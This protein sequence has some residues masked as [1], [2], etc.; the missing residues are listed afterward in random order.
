MRERLARLK[1]PRLRILVEN[2]YDIQKLRIMAGGR[3]WMYSELDAITPAQAAKLQEIQNDMKR[4]EGKLLK[5]IE[6]ELKSVPVWQWLKTVKGIG[7]AM[8][9]GLV[10][11][12]DDISR[13]PHVSSLWKY[14][15]L[16]VV[17]GAAPGRKR[18]EKAPW[19]WRLKTHTWK[20]VKQLL[21]A[22]S[23]KTGGGFYDTWYRKYKSDE[24]EKCERAGM[25]IVPSAGLPTKNKKKYEPEGTISIG[26]VDNRAKRKV[27]KLFL[28]H[29]WH[30]WRA[31]D[32][33]PTESPY[34][35]KLGHR[36]IPPPNW[37][38]GEP[39]RD[40]WE[41]I[42]APSEEIV[43]IL[44]QGEAPPLPASAKKATKCKRGRK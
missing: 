25:K 37:P 17:D 38:L 5:E 6:L 28:A 42:A 9:G 40:R 23:P 1:H 10:A 34:A 12:I 41:E 3:L 11:W 7:P 19:N 27:A 22:Q 33:L 15:G 39:R 16:H 32:G 13:S 30:V 36:V 8:A 44:P 14:A 18:G 26:H 24:V 21:M 35:E 29:V 2:Y 4:D 43:P 20:C 31:M